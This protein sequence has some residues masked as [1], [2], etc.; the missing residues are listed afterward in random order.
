MHIVMCRKYLLCS[1]TVTQVIGIAIAFYL[2]ASF[3]HYSNI[4]SDKGVGCIHRVGT[5]KP[6]KKE[7]QHPSPPVFLPIVYEY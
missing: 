7:I 1:D 3:L 5:G 4:N 6:P 2:S